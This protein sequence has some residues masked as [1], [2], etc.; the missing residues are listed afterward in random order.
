[1]NFNFYKNIKNNKTQFFKKICKYKN[2]KNDK[3]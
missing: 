1:M 2:I 3:F